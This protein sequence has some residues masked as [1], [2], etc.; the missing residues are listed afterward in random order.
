MSEYL[1]AK[2]GRKCVYCDA[3]NVPLNI[4]HV[5]PRSRGG[6]DRITNLVLACIPCN[7]AKGNRWVEEF[8]PDRAA[9]ILARAK[10]PLRD[11][12]AVNSTR[13]ATLAAL[14]SL[15]VAVECATGGRTKFSRHEH[16]VPKAHCL[17]AA[18]VGEMA[19]IRSWAGPVLTVKAMGRGCHQR[20][21][22]DAYGFPRLRLPRSKRVSGF[23]TGDLVRVVIPVG[24]HAGRHVGRVAVRKTGSFRVGTCDGIRHYRCSVL[25]RADGYDHTTEGRE[26]R[27]YPRLKAGVPAPRL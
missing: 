2:F 17:D 1:L 24:K 18:C 19:G 3:E 25:Q 14:R 22:T 5:V 6:S 27:F 4:Y 8:C 11:A 12:A 13:F 16:G 21:R 20:A 26:R 15:G 10:A 7:Q 23:A 9:K